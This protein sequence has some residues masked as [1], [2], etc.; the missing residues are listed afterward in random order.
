MVTVHLKDHPSQHVFPLQ[1]P[2]RLG[3]PPQRI[4]RR[5][6]HAD[7]AVGEMTTQLVEFTRIRDRVEGVHAERAPLHRNRFDA[8]RVDDPSPGPH[9]VETPLEPGTSGERKH[10]IQSVGR[11]RSESIRGFRT[12][13]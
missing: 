1:P 4:R 10:T 5:D 7:P 6:R 3:G 11:E 9:E 2:M 12:P 8:V 13:G